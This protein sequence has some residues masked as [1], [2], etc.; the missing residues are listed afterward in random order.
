M[1]VLNLQ[2][3]LLSALVV[4]AAW[5]G[6]AFAEA[7]PLP[8]PKGKPILTVSGKITVTNNGD[9]AELDRATLESI[10]MQSFTTATPWYQG[11]VKFEGVPFA[12]LLERL[13]STG[14]HLM[15]VALN[16]YSSDIPME[17][18]KKYNVLL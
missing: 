14:Q 1:S 17:D 16:D 15:V 2:K 7:A 13:G 3:A 10:G 12:K 5:A 4:F 18:I 11:P 9:K 6:A 8:P